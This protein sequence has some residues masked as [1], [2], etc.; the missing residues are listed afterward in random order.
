MDETTQRLEALAA[1]VE[2]ATRGAYRPIGQTAA[3][4][5]AAL[6]G[7]APERVLANVQQD[8]GAR[9]LSGELLV[10]A[11]DLVAHVRVAGMHGA[12][13]TP[14][15]DGEIE[16]VAVPRS[17]LRSVALQV[18]DHDV[19][20]RPGLPAELDIELRYEPVAHP[21]TFGLAHLSAAERRELVA[22]FT[23]DLR[24]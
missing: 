1:A 14:P 20:E 12:G 11:A 24:A 2:A 13:P 9:T 18:P 22:A 3:V 23:A 17:A 6:G 15:R 7:Q 8:Q 5:D 16:V 21:L 19:V 4:I 10:V